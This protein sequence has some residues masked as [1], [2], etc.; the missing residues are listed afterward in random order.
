MNLIVLNGG[1]RPQMQLKKRI[2]TYEI[3][4]TNIELFYS[5]ENGRSRIDAYIHVPEPRLVHKAFLTPCLVTVA[6]EIRK[7]FRHESRE[8]NPFLRVWTTRAIEQNLSSA[9]NELEGRILIEG[10]R[11]DPTNKWTPMEGSSAYVTSKMCSCATCNAIGRIS[12]SK[13]REGPF[14]YKVAFQKEK[15][16]SPGKLKESPFAHINVLDLC[17]LYTSPSPRDGA[18]SRM[19]SSA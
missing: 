4:Q 14:P 3:C 16:L 5:D 7:M 9:L 12:D 17:L 13:G 2:G 18:T 6:R 10:Y 19:P 1:L 8:V 11:R 15:E